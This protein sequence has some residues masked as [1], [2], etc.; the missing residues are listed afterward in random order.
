M[1]ICLLL[2]KVKKFR[3]IFKTLL[4]TMEWKTTET[5]LLFHIKGIM[6]SMN[7][8]MFIRMFIKLHYYLLLNIFHHFTLT[9]PV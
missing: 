3:E 5:N 4:K 7:E 6:F 1:I 8:N 9:A 2:F